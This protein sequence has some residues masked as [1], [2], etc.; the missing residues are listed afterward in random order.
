MLWGWAG[1]KPG[2]GYLQGTHPSA[3]RQQSRGEGLQAPVKD[4]VGK[5]APHPSLPAAY[6]TH[7]AGRGRGAGL[8]RGGVTFY[9]TCKCLFLQCCRHFFVVSEVRSP[10][11]KVHKLRNQIRNLSEIHDDRAE[12]V[13]LRLCQNFLT[14][15][16]RKS[17]VRRREVESFPR[18]IQRSDHKASIYSEN[19]MCAFAVV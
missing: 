6:P 16:L 15:C 17:G 14:A 5:P 19:I 2:P 4:R 11:T 18:E 9:N 7:I 10:P 1:C 12:I 13:S 8:R 3:T